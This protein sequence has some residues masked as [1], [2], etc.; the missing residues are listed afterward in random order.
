[1]TY[2][3]G[4]YEIETASGRYVDLLAPLHETLALG[5]VAHGLA[6]T[7]RFGGQCSRFYSVAEHAVLVA[8]K[9]EAEG[10]ADLAMAGLHHD[11]AEAY[12]GDVPRPLKLLLR[13]LT[14]AEDPRE[15][16]WGGLERKM[17]HAIRQASARWGAAISGVRLW[18]EGQAT[19]PTLKA[20]DTWAL[21]VEAGELMPSRG[22]GWLE[23][24]GEAW[25]LRHF[26][27][28]PLERPRA[29]AGG[30][31]PETARLLWL[32]RHAQLV[33]NARQVA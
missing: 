29:W 1:M 10:R 6:H 32:K 2:Q 19:D 24:A 18:T 7:C 3:P 23:G 26:I 28:W 16:T 12:L 15:M 9:L 14:E 22:D 27:A 20:A 33:A 8:D 21:L 30:L 25:D 4:T 13:S 31:Q 5:D 17:D 11:D